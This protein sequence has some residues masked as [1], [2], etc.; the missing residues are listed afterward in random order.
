M[1]KPTDWIENKIKTPAALERLCHSWRVTGQKVVF[2]NG[3]FD[4][5]HPGH[6]RY[7]AAAAAEGN[8]LVVGLNSDVSVK[9]LKGASRPIHQQEDR[10]FQLASLLV[11]DAVCLFEE[12][13]PAALIALVKPDV[14]AK[15]GDYKKENI[16]GAAF[17][18]AQG[19]RVAILPFLEGHSTTGIIG[20]LKG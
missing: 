1:N 11:I 16:V 17:V 14:L 15:G 5:L 10:L 18:E 6:L 13:T 19:G 3:C 4:I 9:R 2:T 12:D 8:K 20:Q 7:L